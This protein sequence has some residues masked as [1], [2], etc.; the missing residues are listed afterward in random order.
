MNR[1]AA[2]S[3]AVVNLLCAACF[4]AIIAVGV[5]LV[6]GWILGARP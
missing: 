2:V 3:A 6:D 1:R 4:V 5:G